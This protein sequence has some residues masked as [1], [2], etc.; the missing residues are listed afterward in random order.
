MKLKVR[1]K[2]LSTSTVKFT[3][4]VFRPNSVVD[5][6]GDHMKAFGSVFVERNKVIIVKNLSVSLQASS[7]LVVCFEP[8]TDFSAS[9]CGQRL[10][11]CEFSPI[12]SCGRF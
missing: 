7:D 10:L 8:H 11:I 4:P 2:V 6:F 3:G 1:R 9:I 12:Q 5:Y